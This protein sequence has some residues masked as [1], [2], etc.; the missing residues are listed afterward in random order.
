MVTID[1]ED[2]QNACI[3][4]EELEIIQEPVTSLFFSSIRNFNFKQTCLLDK[5]HLVI[6]QKCGQKTLNQSL[7]PGCQKGEP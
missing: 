5:I 7:F 6:C 2:A 1:E 4:K 3:H